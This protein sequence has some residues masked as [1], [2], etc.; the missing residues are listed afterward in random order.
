MAAVVCCVREHYA[1]P[2]VRECILEQFSNHSLW[3]LMDIR[4]LAGV[5]K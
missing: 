3:I 2:I 5:K 4:F 1:K